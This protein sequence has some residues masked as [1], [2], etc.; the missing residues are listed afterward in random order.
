MAIV[1]QPVKEQAKR[2]LAIVTNCANDVNKFFREND[3]TSPPLDATYKGTTVAQA[4]AAFEECEAI[5]KWAILH[6]EFGLTDPPANSDADMIAHDPD[7][8]T[9]DDG[10]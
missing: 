6:T 7:I 1:P 4:R 5:M 10:T 2:T 9:F 8:L 3:Q